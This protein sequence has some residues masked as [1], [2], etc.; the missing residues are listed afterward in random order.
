MVRIVRRGPETA[1]VRMVCTAKGDRLVCNLFG[2]ESPKMFPVVG[3]S[4]KR[5]ELE[6][7]LTCHLEPGRRIRCT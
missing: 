4:S 5:L 7:G 2:P 1:G 6:T 3:Y